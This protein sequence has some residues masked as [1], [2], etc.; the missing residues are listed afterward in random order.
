M[1]LVVMKGICLL[2]LLVGVFLLGLVFD[3]EQAQLVQERALE[4][5]PRQDTGA[6]NLR[7]PG[8]VVGALF[9]LLGLYGVVPKLPRRKQ[10]MISYKS[11]HGDIELQL[12]PIRKTL[13]QM[14]RKMPEVYSIKLD[15][16]PDTDGRRARIQADVVLK[17]CAALGARKCSKMVAEY[18][19]AAAR[20]VL[21]LDDLSVVR[22]NVRGVHID[23]SAT[24]KQV[25][26]HLVLREEAETD[27][28][29]LAHSPIAAVTL[30]GDTTENSGVIV[31][32][33]GNEVAE[34]SVCA[35]EEQIVDQETTDNAFPVAAEGDSAPEDEDDVS[36][37]AA[38]EQDAPQ[39]EAI[40]EAA[41]PLSDEAE[42]E[43]DINLPPLTDD[44]EP[45]PPAPQI[46]L[47]GKPADDETSGRTSDFDGETI[48]M[49]EAET[50][51]D[52]RD[53]AADDAE[54]AEAAP[55][56]E[57]EDDAQPIEDDPPESR[58][59]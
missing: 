56:E 35:A 2:V 7:L 14:V 47:D 32:A 23:V 31:D 3:L 45:M 27:A 49:P 9:I 18:L 46:N 10:S 30:D 13:L 25:R 38:H 34:Q 43:A 39:A 44:E 36:E 17:N 26:E 51:D 12:R 6:L 16:T 15:I 11:E 37:P 20:N 19:A 53:S 58:W 21:G 28:Y 33:Q 54:L 1:K 41:E 57:P 24:S 4:Y 59:T 5:W 42:R 48:D 52:A 55:A 22:V 8:V 40:Q 29:A 50:I